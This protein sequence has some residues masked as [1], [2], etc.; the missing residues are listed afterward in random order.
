MS[1]HQPGKLDTDAD[2][3]EHRIMADAESHARSLPGFM[4]RAQRRAEMAR[5]MGSLSRPQAARRVARLPP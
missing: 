4:P 3:D 2:A 5:R 1:S